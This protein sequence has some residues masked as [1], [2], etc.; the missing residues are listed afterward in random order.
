MNYEKMDDVKLAKH[1]RRNSG[2]DQGWVVML[3]RYHKLIWWYIIHHT[4]EEDH[5]LYR[6]IQY[7]IW[8]G[9]ANRH[10]GRGSVLSYVSSIIVNQVK[11]KQGMRTE[12]P[13]LKLDESADAP[14]QS[15]M[16]SEAAQSVL[17]ILNRLKPKERKM[18]ILQYIGHSHEEIVHMLSIS[19][20][21]ADIKYTSRLLDK[22]SYYSQRSGI[23]PE[24]LLYGIRALNRLGEFYEMLGV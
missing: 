7:A 17:D 11:S 18:L 15:D 4:G 23:S 9:L 1:L 19:S 10:N 14:D 21:G 13:K 22:V 20:I 24:R 3:K 2:D 8:D 16:E 12:E 6:D 5:E